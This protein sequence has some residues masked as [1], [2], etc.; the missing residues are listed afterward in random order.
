MALNEIANEIEKAKTDY[1]ESVY[2]AS[3]KAKAELA[4]INND[5]DHSSSWMEQRAN[6]LMEGY[7]ARRASAAADAVSNLEA[8]YADGLDAAAGVLAKLPTPGEAAYL[9]AFMMKPR[10]T[11]SDVEQAMKALQGSA[12]ASASMYARAASEGVKVEGGVPGYIA[13]TEAAERCLDE[14]RV[15]LTTFGAAR[16]TGV[17]SDY[18]FSCDT[19]QAA[20]RM[21]VAANE[22]T[23][24]LRAVAGFE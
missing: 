7:E 13:V 22:F 1:M 15:L 21:K 5:G 24:A 18:S 16:K 12:V 11:P 3:K 19:I 6:E 4:S 20:M 14:D 8:L 17:G 9:Q 23:S 2:G 10:V